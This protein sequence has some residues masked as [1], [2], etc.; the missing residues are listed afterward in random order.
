MERHQTPQVPPSEIPPPVEERLFT[1]WSSENS[2]RERVAQWVQSAISI[3]SF[4]TVNQA[5]QNIREP[6]DNEVLRYALRR[7]NT[8]AK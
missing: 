4:R 5:E 8:Y 7:S 6:D 1:N 3:E 2:P